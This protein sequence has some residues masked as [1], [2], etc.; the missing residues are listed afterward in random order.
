LLTAGSAFVW[1]GLVPLD[2]ALSELT[3]TVVV[4]LFFPL[5]GAVFAVASVVAVLLLTNSPFLV[6]ILLEMPANYVFIG[7]DVLHFWPLLA[8][9]A[10]ALLQRKIILFALN[11]QIV[12]R[13]ILASP[14]RLVF[15]LGYQAY[16]GAGI[17]LAIYST[18]F[19][20]RVVYDTDLPIV[21]GIIVAFLSLTIFNLLPLM[22]VFTVDGA[23]TQTPYDAA[24]L[25][26]N[27]ASQSMTGGLMFQ[28]YTEGRR[29]R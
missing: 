1:T 17:L 18:L 23:G 6:D 25:W 8:I 21:S 13:G 3:Q 11:R 24:W 2:G 27:D 29:T 9:L 14:V 10:F 19:D 22:Y 28:A 4:L 16:G 5:N 26:R 20:P 7:N 15:F 12:E